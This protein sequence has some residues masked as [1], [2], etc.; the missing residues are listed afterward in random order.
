MENRKIMSAKE[1]KLRKFFRFSGQ[2]VDLGEPLKTQGVTVS[3][4]RPGGFRLL[5][6]PGGRQEKVFFSRTPNG[7]VFARI[8]KH[9]Y[10]GEWVE[11]GFD[12]SADDSGSGN[13]FIAQFPGKIRKIL[14]S[15][16]GPIAA[17]TV[18]LML[19]AMKMEFA[20]K[21]SV[22]GEVKAILVTEGQVVTP[23]QKFIEFQAKAHPDQKDAS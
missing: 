11:L 6:F 18:V 10:H 17:G 4:I 23:G 12:Q 16:P 13:E 8:G 19:E 21:A 1:K 20:I 14:V 7:S 3:E 2:R 9:H 5:K 22:A 15:S